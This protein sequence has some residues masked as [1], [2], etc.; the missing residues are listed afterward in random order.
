LFCPLLFSA[1]SKNRLQNRCT[2]TALSTPE[3]CRDLS[4]VTTVD[5]L[6]LGSTEF[7]FERGALTKPGITGPFF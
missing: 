6:R 2:K 1:M 5:Y 4:R 7:V 3:P